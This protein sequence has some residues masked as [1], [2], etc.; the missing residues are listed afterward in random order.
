MRERFAN[1][2]TPAGTMKTFMVQPERPGPFPA[3]ILY[4]DFWGVREELFDIARWL[5]TDGYCCAVPDL[6]YRQGAIPNE[7]YDRQGKMVSLSRLDQATRARVLEPLQKLT[8]AEA[9]EDTAA[10]LRFL[11]AQ[12]SVRAG[13]KGCFGYCLG[14]R[15]AIRAAGSFADEI[16]AGASMHGSR[17]VYDG[18]TS[19]HLLAKH[20][21]GE[22]YCGFAA[23]DPYTP[24]DTPAQIEAAMRSSPARYGFNI[25]AGAEHGYALPNRDIYDK[26]AT[27]RDWEMIL[28]MF[29]RQ[30]PPDTA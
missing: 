11:T 23:H 22:F 30:L 29:H 7:I 24:A 15:M 5:A 20:F 14:G 3:V 2:A 17:L 9:M 10:L 18:E 27:L 16:K 6:Y 12:P 19:P 25:H 28:A 21:Q 26:Q 13:A 4:M 1:V 8:D